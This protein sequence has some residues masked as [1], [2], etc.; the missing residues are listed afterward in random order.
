[1]QRV[2]LSSRPIKGQ[3][4][5]L[6]QP[7]P[8]RMLDQQLLELP[9]EL[10]VA[11]QREVRLD[12][13][14]EGGDAELF[15]A[16]DRRPRERLVRQVGERGAA[17][18]AE[19][20]PQELRRLFRVICVERLR[21]QPLE[22]DQV[23]LLRHEADRVARRARLDWRGGSER[24]PQVRDLALHLLESRHRSGTRVEIIGEPV[25]RDDSVRIQKQER[26]RRPLLWPA[27]LDDAIAGDLERS[28]E[29]VLEH[30]ADRTPP[31]PDRNRRG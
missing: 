23:E 17:P 11:T 13:L 29:P 3:H 5:L 20:L 1:M 6:A 31:I 12:P 15:E 24:L 25:Y 27:Q 7:L 22:H 10:G 21:G 4:E 28:Q 26:E 9:D 30:A 19:R 18:E 8:Q 14:L 16:L 2:R